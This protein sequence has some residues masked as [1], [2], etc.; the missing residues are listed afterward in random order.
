ML[1]LPAVLHGLWVFSNFVFDLRFS[2][3]MMGV[4]RIVLSS[5]F[6]GFTGFAEEVIPRSLAKTGVI[7]WDHLYRVL[8]FL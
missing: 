2:S 6:Y 8:P 4:L 7:P 5:G 3:T 1:E